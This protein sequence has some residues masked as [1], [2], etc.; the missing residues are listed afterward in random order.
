MSSNTSILSSKSL[1]FGAYD[2]VFQGRYNVVR[3]ACIN[4]DGTYVNVHIG[5]VIR[6]E[7]IEKD[8]IIF[9]FYCDELKSLSNL[10][11]IKH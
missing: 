8:H 11:L 6:V 7:K 5:T 3:N 4:I 1:R 9:R 10:M 2:I